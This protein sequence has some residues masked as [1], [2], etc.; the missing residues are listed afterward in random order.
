MENQLK[1]IEK[2]IPF[3]VNYL[4]LSKNI[5]RKTFIYIILSVLF[6]IFIHLNTYIYYND[7]KDIGCEC[8]IENGNIDAIY[9]YSLAKIGLMIF[10][11]LLFSIIYMK[12]Y[13]YIR[14]YETFIKLI[15]LLDIALLVYW[16]YS[17]YIY[18]NELVKNNCDCGSHSNQMIIYYY[19]LLIIS[20]ITLG[21]LNFIHSSIMN[22]STNIVDYLITKIKG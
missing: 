9:Y 1:L 18:N 3:R 16:T 14:G 10:L 21:I 8:A 4:N 20:A 19:S 6:Q 2:K 15:M 13:A 17:V 22:S 5:N 11:I 7:M 12:K